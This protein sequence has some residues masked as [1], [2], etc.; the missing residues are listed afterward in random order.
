MRD[1]PVELSLVLERGQLGVVL[2]TEVHGRK[3]VSGLCIENNYIIFFCTIALIT[4][5]SSAN[6]TEVSINQEC[7]EHG[8]LSII[9]SRI[10]ERDFIDDS[11]RH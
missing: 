4:S 7:G 10:Q 8:V 9:H 5:F 6:S 1:D 11:S 3:P 2:P